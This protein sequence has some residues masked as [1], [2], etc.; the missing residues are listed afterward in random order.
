MDCSGIV[1]TG[2]IPDFV[3]QVLSGWLS[4]QADMNADGNVDGLDVQG[5]V[6]AM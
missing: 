4:C 3:Q 5:F 2:D 1:D 6:A